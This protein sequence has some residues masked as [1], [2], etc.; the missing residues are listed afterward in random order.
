MLPPSND[1]TTYQ[2]TTVYTNELTALKVLLI[3]YSLLQSLIDVPLNEWSIISLGLI[4]CHCSYTDAA[5]CYAQAQ[6][7]F[8]EVALKFIQVEERHALR[9]FLLK[10]LDS[11][12]S[13][14]RLLKLQ[15]SFWLS[16]LLVSDLLCSATSITKNQKFPSQI[17]IIATSFKR[18]LFDC[19]FFL[20]LVIHTPNLPHVGPQY[21]LS[22]CLSVCII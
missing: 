4:I 20:S 19:I 5:K 3:D 2:Q 1:Q 11:L 9:M 15:S 7:S 14:V 12:K 10:K 22:C 8:E 21:L 17:A 6:V 16:P 18:L 13:Q